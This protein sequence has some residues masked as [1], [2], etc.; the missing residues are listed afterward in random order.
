MWTDQ[1]GGSGLGSLSCRLD[2]P[3]AL[4]ELNVAIGQFLPRRHEGRGAKFE[5]GA[6]PSTSMFGPSSIRTM[7]SRF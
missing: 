1:G 6:G 3:G 4:A 5:V 2:D 7:Y